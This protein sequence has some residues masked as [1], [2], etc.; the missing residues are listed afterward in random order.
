MKPIK[1]LPI[2]IGI[3][4][5]DGKILMLQRKDKNPMWDKKWEFPGGKIEEGED[6][7]KAVCRE[8]EEETGLRVHQAEYFGKHIHDWNLEDKILRVHIHCFHCVAKEG[9][10]ILETHG[11]YQSRWETFERALEYDS[12]EANAYLLK[13]L[14]KVYRDKKLDAV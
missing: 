12:L 6:L 11:A 1:E 7:E 4:E 8:V 9:E 13:T 2:V 14:F 5:R 10:V 3:V